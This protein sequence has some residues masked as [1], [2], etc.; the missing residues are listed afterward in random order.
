[1]RGARPILVRIILSILALVGEGGVAWADTKAALVIGNSK[2][3][4]VD[5][6]KYVKV[7]PLKNPANDATAV[8]DALTAIG[9]NVILKQDV[10]EREFEMTL[11]DFAREAARADIAL[12]YFAGHGVQFQGQNYLLP[13]DANLIDSND[14]EFASIAME[15]AIS[16]TSKAQKIKIIVLDAC[17]SRVSVHNRSASR[18]LPDIGISE[19]LAPIT[20]N[21]SNADGMIIFYSAEPGMEA[22]DGAGEA[23]SPF[24]QSFSRRILARNVKIQDVF[25]LVSSDVYASTNKLQ[26]PEVAKDELTGDV[27]LNPAETA[28]E[29]WRRIRNSIDPADFRR[30]ISDYPDSGLADAAQLKLDKFD[31]DRRAQDQERARKEAEAK[32]AAAAAAMAA[33]EKREQHARAAQQVQI[34]KDRAEKEAAAKALAEKQAQMDAA[35]KAAEDRAAEERRKVAQAAAEATAEQARMA[36]EKADKEAEAKRLAEEAAAAKKILADEADAARKAADREAVEKAT[37]EAEVEAEAARKLEAAERQAKAEEEARKKEAAEAAAR[38]AIAKA[39]RAAEEE[40]EAA[41]KLE[42][43]KQ[44]A[45][46][47]EEARKRE[48]AETA[49]KAIADAC[50]RDF[51]DLAQLKDARQSEAIQALRSHT[52]CPTLLAAADQAI[53]DITVDQANQCAAD[54]KAL[55]RV[56]Q[57]SEDALKVTLDALKC[58]A[59]RANASAQIAKLEDDNLR[60]QRTCADERGKFASIDLFAP[61]ARDSLTALPQSP[62]CQ[63]VV[64]DIR[65][66]IAAVDK[67]IA[68]AQGELNRLGCYTA[69]PTG[70]FDKATIAAV[71]DYLKGRHAS[72]GAPK[73]TDAFVDELSQQ[74]F[75]VCVAPAPSVAAYPGGASLP[76][77][78]KGTPP[79]RTPARANAIETSVEAH[80][81]P[82]IARVRAAPSRVASEPPAAPHSPYYVPAF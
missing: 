10:T 60:A 14:I 58:P 76:A 38:E 46:A 19:G 44:Q 77:R 30:F 75:V 21:I 33:L 25:N 56:D 4:S 3:A 81:P 54:Q 17:R 13:V 29:V 68:N 65:G 78:Q 47:E 12:F 51:A 71:T 70:R 16:A 69:K 55:A 57:K 80:A 8:K 22:Q 45:K 37:R 32:A 50:I 66:A 41:R 72:P 49:A 6:S 82:R 9:F 27:M 67:R 36:K 63:E 59:V 61:A 26:H 64:T 42:A 52:D 79:L 53:N 24:A 31:S 20:N 11:G 74:D 15:R 73:I 62:A 40:A 23:N 43:A 39:K 34:E 5:P 2:Y 48:A 35:K 7:D 28:E 1:M 18:S